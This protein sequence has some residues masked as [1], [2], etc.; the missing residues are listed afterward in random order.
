[1]LGISPAT[2]RLWERQGL[3]QP[4]RTRGG[5]PWYT[6][7]DLTHPRRSQHLRQVEH[8]SLRASA[9]LLRQPFDGMSPHP[10]TNGASAALD[11]GD[12]LA[13]PARRGRRLQGP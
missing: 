5:N 2:L 3:I 1:A 4:S 8:L 6:E 10:I 9:L 7:D 13:L 12:R 11:V